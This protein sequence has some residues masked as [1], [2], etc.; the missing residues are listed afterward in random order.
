MT[1]PWGSNNPPLLE[2]LN[3]FALPWIEAPSLSVPMVGLFLISLIM[4]G[5]IAYRL[6]YA[7]PDTHIYDPD[8][9]DAKFNGIKG[10]LIPLSAVLLLQPLF[11][12]MALTHD[13]YPFISQLW[14]ISESRWWHS[15]LMLNVIVAAAEIV[16][17]AVLVALWLR[18]KRI[19]RWVIVGVLGAKL[20]A[21]LLRDVILPQLFGQ[22]YNILAASA[23]HMFTIIYTALVLL[24]YLFFSRRVHATFRN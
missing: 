15:F 2:W 23:D 11:A 5:G 1:A 18:R 24:P 21:A 6:Y 14:A 7:R 12:V 17:G 22:Y 3:D 13:Y 19:I 4:S 8:Q 9:Y 20:A 10:F 16:G